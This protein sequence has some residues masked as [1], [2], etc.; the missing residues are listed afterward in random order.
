[1][2]V[3]LI[4]GRRERRLRGQF[5][6]QPPIT[7]QM[8]WVRPVTIPG[9]DDAQCAEAACDDPATLLRLLRGLAG[10]RGRGRHDLQRYSG[11]S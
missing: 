6:C 10:R 4:H 9:A 5:S 7:G 3:H 8:V 2:F 11:Q 1:M